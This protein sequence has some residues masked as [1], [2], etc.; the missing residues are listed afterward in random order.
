MVV[1]INSGE[2][3]DLIALLINFV[4]AFATAVIAALVY[5]YTRKSNKLQAMLEFERRWSDFNK[6]LFQSE[7]M[8]KIYTELNPDNERNGTL[9]ARFLYYFLGQA[10]TAY[11][12]FENKIISK[13]IYLRQME[14][15]KYMSGNSISK[16]FD[17]IK[18]S[19]YPDGF[20]KDLTGAQEV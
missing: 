9:E 20:V 2:I 7:D 13:E 19:G 1:D 6:T 18:S 3:I 8:R 11:Y 12:L 5:L 15:V 16:H 4:G 17:M 10:L 14:M